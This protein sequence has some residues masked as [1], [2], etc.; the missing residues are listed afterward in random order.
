[1][2]VQGLGSILHQALS[3]GGQVK[4]PSKTTAAVAGLLKPLEIL[5]Q[6]G[7]VSRT[8]ASIVGDLKSEQVAGEF[9]EK[10]LRKFWDEVD[11]S[12][13]L[14]LLEQ[15]SSV[16]IQALDME[17]PAMDASIAAKDLQAVID[18]LPA[19]ERVQAPEAL[20]RRRHPLHIS[21]VKVTI[22]EGAMN[23]CRGGSRATW[24]AI[25]D[26]PDHPL[27]LTYLAEDLGLVQ[28][29]GRSETG[30][31][32]WTRD[33]RPVTP[34]Q[35][36]DELGSRLLHELSGLRDLPLGG[37]GS[38]AD[39]LPIPFGGMLPGDLSQQ[40]DLLRRMGLHPEQ[41]QGT[42][43]A[44]Q[45]SHFQYMSRAA[46]MMILSAAE[47]LPGVGGPLPDI[48]KYPHRV[49][50][51]AAH[52]FPF[53]DVWFRLFQFAKEGKGSRSTYEILSGLADSALGVEA[54]MEGATP[55]DYGTHKDDP[56]QLAEAIQAIFSA[57]L[58][59]MPA[60]MTSGP[61]MVLSG[62]CASPGYALY[63]GCLMLDQISSLAEGP[64]LVRIHGSDAPFVPF[65]APAILAGYA[66][67]ALNVVTVVAN[68]V[69]E[70][71][72]SGPAPKNVEGALA[73]WKGLSPA[74]KWEGLM[75][76]IG[77][78]TNRARG[79]PIGEGSLS[80]NLTSLSHSLFNRQFP[81]SIVGACVVG[82]GEGWLK[83]L[84]GVSQGG[85]TTGKIGLRRAKVEHGM[86]PGVVMFHF[87]NT[88][89][90]NV[91]E[92][93]SFSHVLKDM[94]LRMRVAAIKGL[95]GHV[96]GANPD[97][98]T[99]I[100]ILGEQRTPG[101]IGFDPALI[102]E[103]Y[104]SRMPEALERLEMSG[105]PYAGP[106]NSGLVNQFG[107]CNK[108][109]SF[110]LGH[111]PQPKSRS[112]H[113]LL[114]AVRAAREVFARYEGANDYM[115]DRWAAGV[116]ETLAHEASTIDRLRRREIQHRDIIVENGSWPPATALI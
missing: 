81:T 103:R 60:A 25:I 111:V 73:R 15:H 54:N 102:D 3:F 29:T 2:K 83:D 87:T 78:G 101:I 74:E 40:D 56:A 113:D 71:L 92:V 68:M 24:R 79:L 96:Q 5:H 112:P 115:L 8:M 114:D 9:S 88:K 4:E 58:A 14:T 36:K 18:G 28:Y 1:M 90:S 32:Q 27:A 109:A 98:P 42:A 34:L 35:V 116:A 104:A 48:Y 94:G 51:V 50:S 31:E 12:N 99:V 65:E 44:S 93:H 108:N 95:T 26:G 76:S 23:T 69:T 57:N 7:I 91:A 105:Q 39:R 37:E 106:I 10:K 80:Y 55:F 70:G 82:G 89:V 63:A 72:I 22:G 53:L 30:E 77:P 100:R 33:G 20:I 41:L 21:Q 107:F 67:A 19:D 46:A 62:A 64:R 66:G 6:H 75:R 16:V 47:S 52:A 84:A 38:R 86:T 45:K 97:I 13:I 43:F 11:N 85:V 110:I 59:D 17:G 49:G 61:N